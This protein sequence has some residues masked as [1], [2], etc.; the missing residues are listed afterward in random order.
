M[1]KKGAKS[2]RILAPRCKSRE[3]EETGDKTQVVIGFLAVAVFKVE[4]T[5]GEELDYQQLELPPFP[6]QEKAEE[7]GIKVIPIA[8][9][10]KFS[11]YFSGSRKEI[12]LA[13][14]EESVFFHELSH[15]AHERVNGALKTRPRLEAGSRCRTL[16]C[17]ALP[18]CRKKHRNIL[19][20]TIGISNGTPVR[21][22]SPQSMPVC[23]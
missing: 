22:I 18:A 19:V 14:K 12:G 5:D 6:L 23:R 11:G 17:L 8:G 13:T 10:F 20:I 1:S 4:D 15:A 16:G 3:D 7:W 21:R 9:N 2:F